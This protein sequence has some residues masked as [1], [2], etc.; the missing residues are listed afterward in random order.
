[1]RA[2]CDTP[3]ERLPLFERQRFEVDRSNV[4]CITVWHVLVHRLCRATGSGGSLAMTFT[5]EPRS[6][7]VNNNDAFYLRER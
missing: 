3:L 2:A 4:G 1:M 5:C 6:H 7:K